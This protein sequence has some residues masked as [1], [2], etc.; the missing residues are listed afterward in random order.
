MSQSGGACGGGCA[1]LRCFFIALGGVGGG[2]CGGTQLSWGACG[3][4]LLISQ[5]AA[6]CGGQNV[7]LHPEVQFSLKTQP[8]PALLQAVLHTVNQQH[9]VHAQPNGRESSVRESAL[10]RFAYSQLRTA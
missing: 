7:K 6:P 10:S 8:L 3:S 1:A 2:A 9:Q 5:K 4:C